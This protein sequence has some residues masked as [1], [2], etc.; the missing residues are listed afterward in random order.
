MVSL[1]Q[2]A[3]L[4][5]QVKQKGLTTDVANGMT[6][7]ELES[8][9]GWADKSYWVHNSPIIDDYSYDKLVETLRGK[10]PANK[11]IRRIGGGDK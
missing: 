4:V 10:D 7:E 11:L 2:L 1:L 8:F 3:V 5:D 6:I 9:I